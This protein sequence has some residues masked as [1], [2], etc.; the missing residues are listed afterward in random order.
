[1]VIDFPWIN[2]VFADLLTNTSDNIQVPFGIF[3]TNMGVFGTF[4]LGLTIYAFFYL[5]GRTYF[6]GN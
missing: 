1:M 6:S 5:V 3:Y 4:L 2:D